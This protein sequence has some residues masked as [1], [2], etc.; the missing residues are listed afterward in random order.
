MYSLQNV[1]YG[2]LRDAVD[3]MD[4]EKISRFQK[5][6]VFKLLTK[7]LQTIQPKLIN[8]ESSERAIDSRTTN[9]GSALT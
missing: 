6:Q 2:A 3:W 1:W 9:Y 4:E 7:K 5:F 8:V